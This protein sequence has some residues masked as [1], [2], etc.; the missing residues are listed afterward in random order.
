MAN[1]GETY[2]RIFVRERPADSVDFFILLFCTREMFDILN[3]LK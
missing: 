1:L 2:D 3:T